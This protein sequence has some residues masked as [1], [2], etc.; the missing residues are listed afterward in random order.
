M[1]VQLKIVTPLENAVIIEGVL[2]FNWLMLH[3][4][5]SSLTFK[6]GVR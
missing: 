6:G 4:T 1:C 3:V 2:C 5:V